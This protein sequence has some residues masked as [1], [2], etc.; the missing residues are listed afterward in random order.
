MVTA[1]PSTIG[2]PKRVDVRQVFERMSVSELRMF[3]FMS[4]MYYRHRITP[5][6]NFERKSVL[7]YF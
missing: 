5:N 2:L 6:E 7:F 3:V 4:V 1:G